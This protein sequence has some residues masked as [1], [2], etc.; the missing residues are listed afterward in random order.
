MHPCVVTFN[1][2]STLYAQ[3]IGVSPCPLFTL[4]FKG[5]R[6]VYKAW[7]CGFSLAGI[8]GSNPA[9]GMDV[10]LVYVVCVLQAEVSAS[11]WSLVQRI[12]TA[13]ARA[14]VCVTKCGQ[15]QK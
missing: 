14:R 9:G 5:R 2:Q 4:M 1:H 10:S 12:P 13:C 6:A 15:V 8:A 3:H 7:I 11:G